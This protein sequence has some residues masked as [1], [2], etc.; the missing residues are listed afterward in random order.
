[1]RRI[2]EIFDQMLDVLIFI[3]F[4]SR[5]VS[6]YDITEKILDK[7]IRTAQRY[8]RDLEQLGFIKSKRRKG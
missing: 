6:R 1:M 2:T 7:E 8:L 5:A 4:N 3:T